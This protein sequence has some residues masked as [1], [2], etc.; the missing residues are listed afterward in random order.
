MDSKLI[1]KSQKRLLSGHFR[2]YK[3]LRTLKNKLLYKYWR[4]Q[5]DDRTHFKGS[6]AIQEKQ[7]LRSAQIKI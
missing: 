1:R 4:I 6:Y 3:Y 2:K 5:R 7:K